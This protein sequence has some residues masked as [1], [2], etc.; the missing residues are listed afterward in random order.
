MSCPNRNAR[1]MAAF[2][3]ALSLLLPAS[4]LAKKDKVPADQTEA[5]K[6]ITE[7]MKHWYSI[8]QLDGQYLRFSSADKRFHFGIALARVISVRVGGDDARPGYCTVSWQDY[9]HDREDCVLIYREDK[10]AAALRY[11][12]GAAREQAQT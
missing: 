3:L 8:E 6:W 7:S 1:A 9:S 12:A 5:T 2:L 4:L 11:L 10:F